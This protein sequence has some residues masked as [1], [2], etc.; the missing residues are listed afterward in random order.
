MHPIRERPFCLWH[1]PTR[2]TRLRGVP[3]VDRH[4]PRTSLFRF[5]RE[6]VEKG[7]PP[8]IVCGLREMAP[9]DALDVEGFVDDE[10]VGIC[11]LARMLVVEVPAL[12][13][14][15]LVQAGDSLTGLAAAPRTFLLSGHGPLRHAELLLRLPVVA[16]RL[17]GLA[18]GGNEEA[19]EAEVYTYCRSVSGGFRGTPEI[20]G[21]D[22]VP[23]AASTLHRDGFDSSFDGAVQFDLDVSGILEVE[24][25]VTL[26]TAA[27]AIGGE[28]DSSESVFRFESGVAGSV[29]DFTRRKNALNALSSLRSV[30]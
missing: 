23:L 9:R 27:V 1:R 7:C 4:D 2:A 26:Q 6:D 25:S 17:D 29:P 10:A 24:S 11:Q 15:F 28:L 3:G 5:V 8:C 21:E 12:V 18:I 13:R 16:R 30:A 14:R 19:L 22:H 20:A